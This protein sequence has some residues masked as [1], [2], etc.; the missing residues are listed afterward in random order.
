VASSQEAITNGHDDDDTAPRNATVL[1]QILGPNGGWCSGSLVTSNAVLSAAHC[2]IHKG[3]IIHFGASSELGNGTHRAIRIVSK[4]P[5]VNNAKD[6]ARDVAIVRFDPPMTMDASPTRPSFQRPPLSPIGSFPGLGIGTVNGGISGYG[7]K[8]IGSGGTIQVFSPDVRQVAES[9][10]FGVAHYDTGGGYV[11]QVKFRYPNDRCDVAPCT[12][13]GAHK[14]DLDS[15][16]GTPDPNGPGC[17]TPVVGGTCV[18]SA[19]AQIQ[20]DGRWYVPPAQAKT[21]GT[22][23]VFCEC[24]GPFDTP[25][26][27]RANCINGGAHCPWQASAFKPTPNL[28]TPLTAKPSFTTLPG[29][30]EVGTVDVFSYEQKT[31]PP[32]AT[33]AKSGGFT[34]KTKR[35]S[36]PS[37]SRTA[38][39]STRPPRR[40]SAGAC[41]LAS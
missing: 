10:Q 36:G 30:S 22:G 33:R 11:E 23:Y 25:S 14:I 6:P 2:E 26:Q 17:A 40:A 34:T 18:F 28:L 20:H 15:S 4:E 16:Y 9:S 12:Q 13:L 3:D 19:N 21:G 31:N 37:A 8:A 5:V 29:T 27:L 39:T 7:D 41:P 32:S 35:R 38:P 24:T 1:I